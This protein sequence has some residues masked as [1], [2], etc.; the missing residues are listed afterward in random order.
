MEVANILINAAKDGD[1]AAWYES[2]SQ[3]DKD[4]VKAEIGKYKKKEFEIQRE[5]YEKKINNHINDVYEYTGAILAIEVHNWA[6]ENKK[7]DPF[8]LYFV[9]N[10]T[11]WNKHYAEVTIFFPLIVKGVTPPLRLCFI[12]EGGKWKFDQTITTQ[13]FL[14]TSGEDFNKFVGFYLDLMKGMKFD[15]A[16]TS[17]IKKREFQINKTLSEKYFSAWHTLSNQEKNELSIINIVNDEDKKEFLLTWVL[18]GDKKA[19]EIWEQEKKSGKQVFDEI[20]LNWSRTYVSEGKAAIE[21]DE[22]PQT[23]KAPSTKAEKWFSDIESIFFRQILP[24]QNFIKKFPE[25]KTLCAKAQYQIAEN[26]E[27]AN[28]YELAEREYLNLLKNYPTAAETAKA[29]ANLAKL[30]EKRLRMQ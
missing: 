16:D 10:E 24:Y 4:M 29:K 3:T 5:Y 11:I 28:E 21:T 19:E 23:E 27:Y 14:R 15:R 30:P 20:E 12:K 9:K 18:T 25:E 6:N 7:L 2:I 22:N 13:Q 17:K 26:Y 1:T 8:D